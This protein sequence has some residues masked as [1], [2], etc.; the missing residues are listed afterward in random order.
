M[1]DRLVAQNQ[2]VGASHKCAEHLKLT[3]APSQ[4]GVLSSLNHLRIDNGSISRFSM[5]NSVTGG[6]G[7]VWF[8]T[9]RTFEGFTPVAVKELRQVGNFGERSRTALV[10]VHP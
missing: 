10:S 7:T 3:A 9:L 8:G 6:Y 4:E 5:M 1:E 2:L